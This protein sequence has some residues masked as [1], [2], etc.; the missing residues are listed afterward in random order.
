[1]H[2]VAAALYFSKALWSV[3]HDDYSNMAPVFLASH[4]KE[5]EKSEQSLYHLEMS[6]HC[7]KDTLSTSHSN[8]NLVYHQ[9]VNSIEAGMLAS[10]HIEFTEVLY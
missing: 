3:T 7:L 8:Y 9:F 6:V 2:L 10:G 1:M 5:H 4:V